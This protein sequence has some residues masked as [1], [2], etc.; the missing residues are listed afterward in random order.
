MKLDYSSAGLGKTYTCTNTH[1]V[2]SKFG[3][4]VLHS[5]NGIQNHDTI[6]IDIYLRTVSL[7]KNTDYNLAVYCIFGNM[8]YNGNATISIFSIIK[9]T[10]NKGSDYARYVPR[11]SS[12]HI[13]S[14]SYLKNAPE[15]RKISPYSYSRTY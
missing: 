4:K 15:F 10:F 14:S 5:Q 11:W 8:D 9:P 6:S 1:G 2:C 13:P 3:G 7:K 12:K